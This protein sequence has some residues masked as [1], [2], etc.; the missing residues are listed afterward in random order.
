M[1]PRTERL[2]SSAYAS[3]A[4]SRNAPTRW[5]RMARRRRSAG[6]RSIPRQ[7]REPLGELGR[8]HLAIR[9][10]AA[11]ERLERRARL[12]IAAELDQHERAVEPQHAAE[13]AADDRHRIGRL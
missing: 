8:L 13:I 9:E 3:C 1:P 6:I 11:R 4:T 10:L 7:L 12:R 5:I 2:R